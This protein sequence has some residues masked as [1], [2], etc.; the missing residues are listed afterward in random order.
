MKKRRT[1][2]TTNS[3]K[4][5]TTKAVETVKET[6][7]KAADKIAEEIPVLAEEIC[8]KISEVNV[9]IFETNVSL[10]AIEKSVKKE[11]SDKK[12]KGDIKIYINAEHRTAF[13]TV[14]GEGAKDYKID[15]RTL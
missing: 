13:Y 12:L 2:K 10:D 7:E 15:L 11:V 6:V 14:N 9:E 1:Q 4:T 8:T 5:T 3:I